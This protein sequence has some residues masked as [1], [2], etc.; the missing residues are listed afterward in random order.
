[1]WTHTERRIKK[2]RQR[3]MQSLNTQCVNSATETM[4][5]EDV[6]LKK[7]ITDD[8]LSDRDALGR[9]DTL[10]FL[11]LYVWS[12][13]STSFLTNLADFSILNVNMFQCL[14]SSVDK[15]RRVM[16]S[17]WC[18]VNH[19]S[20]SVTIFWHFTD[21]NGIFDLFTWFLKDISVHFLLTLGW[22]FN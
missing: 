8:N 5:T 3:L 18:F 4:K 1:M 2:K 12:R 22:F 10:K 17:S 9:G 6:G 19:W 16:T 20:I 11:L 13:L 14:S 21:L 15:T 7:N